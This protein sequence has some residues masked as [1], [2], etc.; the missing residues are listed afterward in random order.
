MA[1]GSAAGGRRRRRGSGALKRE[2]GLR[3][4]GRLPERLGLGQ[5][6]PLLLRRGEG[7]GGLLGEGGRLRRQGPGRR[8]GGQRRR[9]EG[10]RALRAKRGLRRRLVVG[11][12]GLGEGEHPGLRRDVGH[13]DHARA[14]ATVAHL[15]RERRGQARHGR[16]R[17]EGRVRHARRDVCRAQLGRRDLLGGRRKPRRDG[18]RGR[19]WRLSGQPAPHLAGPRFGGGLLR[20]DQLHVAPAGAKLALSGL[21]G[22][23]G[24]PALPSRAPGLRDRSGRRCDRCRAAPPP[25]RPP[26]RRWRR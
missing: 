3:S 19:H 14:L 2:I 12:G 8:G 4:Q 13:V 11:A 9:G 23:R 20:A 26:A 15:P 22:E 24:E 5:S 17:D 16:S 7:Q 1:R 25:C 10:Q 18:R 21:L 6:V